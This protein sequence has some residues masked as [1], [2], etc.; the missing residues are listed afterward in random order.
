[1]VPRPGG[2]FPLAL[3]VKSDGLQAL[4]LTLLQEYRVEDY[5]L[6]DVSVPDLVVSSRQGLRAFVIAL[7][8]VRGR[9]GWSGGK[10]WEYLVARRPE[11]AVSDSDEF[12][13]ATLIDSGA[14]VGAS[15]PHEIADRL[16]GFFD[17]WKR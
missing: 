10:M 7:S 15:T 6:F 3:N 16:N 12:A 11:L 13:R 1:M 2:D 8:D 14:E 4:L 5:I 17:E 9:A